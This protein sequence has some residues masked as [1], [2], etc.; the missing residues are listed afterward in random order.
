MPLSYAFDPGA[1]LD[2]VTVDVP[3]A[4]L[5]H[6]RAADFAWQVP[7]LRLTF[8]V[9]DEDGHEVATGKDLPALQEP[10]ALQPARGLGEGRAQPLPQPVAGFAR[11]RDAVRADLVPATET[12]V[13]AVPR[14]LVEARTARVRLTDLTAPSLAAVRH[15]IGWQLDDLAGPGFV[16][17]AGWDRL[18]ELARYARGGAGASRPAG[19]RR[20]ARPRP[21]GRAA[22]CAR[23][24]RPGARRRAARPTAAGRAGRG[25]MADRGAAAGVVR[26][27]GARHAR[28]VR[29]AHPTPSG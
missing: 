15:D 14:V 16:A 23:C 4:L 24:V 12:A 5:H 3:L 20:P 1:D 18:G 27:V 19:R 9:V 28:G 22:R 8:R 17:A 11:L 6:L 21:A 26:P 13:N 10:G 2:G 29:Q 25:P 7:G